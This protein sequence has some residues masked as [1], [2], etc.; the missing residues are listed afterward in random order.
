MHKNITKCNKTKSKWCLNKHEAS[1][2]IDMF[3][4]YQVAMGDSPSKI[5][6][7]DCIPAQSLS[8]KM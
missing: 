7:G 5:E 8:I 3:E 2:I 6:K 1:K 4:T